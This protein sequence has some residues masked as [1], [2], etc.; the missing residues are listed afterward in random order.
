MTSISTFN[1]EITPPQ[2]KHHSILEA[3]IVEDIER[4]FA[5]PLPIDMI[6]HT[7]NASLAPLGCIKQETINERGERI[8]KY[9]M[10]HDQSFPGPSSL[11]VNLHVKKDK[12]PAC[13]YSFVL[14]R[15]LHY[16]ASIRLRHPYTPIYLSK[17]DL[18]AAYRRCHLASETASE[19]LTIYNNYLLTTLWMTFGRAPCP[20]LWGYISDMIADLSNALIQDTPFPPQRKHVMKL[21]IS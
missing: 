18:D 8:P 17:F 19:C 13:M 9:W 5:L 15:T 3:I 14:M 4:G 16:I 21:L 6:H 12:L 7:P 11:S 2:K 10:T 20:P 1:E